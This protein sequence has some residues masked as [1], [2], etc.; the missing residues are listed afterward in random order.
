MP[1][2]AAT[3]KPSPLSPSRFDRYTQPLTAPTS[4]MAPNSASAS[5]PAS[6]PPSTSA[7]TQ[8]SSNTPRRLTVVTRAPTLIPNYERWT[9]RLATPGLDPSQIQVTNTRLGEGSYGQVW[10]GMYLGSPVAIKVCPLHRRQ[11]LSSSKHSMT[12][13]HFCREVARYQKIRHHCI[14]S[15]YGVVFDDNANNL[16]LITELMRGGSL[17][18]AI[19]ALRNAAFQQLHFASV[20]KIASQISNG[21]YYLHRQNFTC[22]DLKTLNILL[23]AQPDLTN[24]TFA[25]NVQVKL[26]DFGLSKNLTKLLKQLR[27]NHNA[28]SR[29]PKSKVYGTYAYLPP[30]SFSLDSESSSDHLVVDAKAADI[31]ALGIVLWEL[32]TLHVPWKGRNA[33]Q[34][35]NL[36]G[37]EG[38][39]PPWPPY[40]L[41]HIPLSFIKL[42]ERCW[43]QNPKLR[44]SAMRVSQ[45]LVE[46]MS[47]L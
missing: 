4:P 28:E 10:L 13:E 7:T 16:Y 6:A 29:S 8:H 47:T 43:H 19:S 12:L 36:V 37:K 20:V 31:Y 5:S 25:P 27:L 2:T 14:I 1:P 3:A 45:T 38:K 21:L 26:C 46:M 9:S 22:G 34:V 42:T 39:R 30:E 40:T 11:G 17:F 41:Q 18:H 32:A 44:P 33:L 35:V 23:S 24:G 15:Y